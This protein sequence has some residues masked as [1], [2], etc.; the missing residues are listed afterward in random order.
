MAVDAYMSKAKAEKNYIEANLAKDLAEKKSIEAQN[1]RK[2]ADESAAMAMKEKK[3]ADSAKIIAQRSLRKAVIAQRQAVKS[4]LEAEEQKKLAKA[5]E[6]IAKEKQSEALIQKDNA[7]KAKEQAEKLKQIALLETEFYPIMLRLE[8]LI[9]ESSEGESNSIILTTIRETLL[10]Y[11]TYE[12]LMLETNSGKIVTE[13]LFILLQTALKAMENKASYRET[14]MLIKKIRQT[15][16]IF[17][18]I[19]C[20]FRI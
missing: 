20:P 6:Q 8:N 13:G 12:K 7:T 11:Y 19:L 9:N 14:S 16:T 10:K 17:Y 5:S 2:I 18:F 1:A 4:A 15:A 3:L